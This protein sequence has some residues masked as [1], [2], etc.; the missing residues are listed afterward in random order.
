M[1]NDYNFNFV[2]FGATGDLT[3]RKLIPALYNLYKNKYINDFLITCIA[4]KDYTNESF[5]DELKTFYKKDLM[6]KLD[7]KL[8]VKFAKKIHYYR[9][10]F[11]NLKNI[12]GLDLFFSNIEKINKIKANRLYYLATL[13]QNYELIINSIK[14]CSLDNEKDGWKRLIIEKPFG[15]SLESAKRLNKILREA[16]REDQIFRIDHYLSKETLNNLLI[17]RFANTIFEPIWS[18]RYIDHVQ[19]TVAEDLGVLDRGAYYDKSGAIRDMLQNHLLQ[20]LTM[21]AMECPGEFVASR[22]RERKVDVLKSVKVDNFILGQYQGYRNEQN[23]EKNSNTETYVSLKLFINNSNWK[24]VPFYIRTGKKMKKKSAFIYIKFKEIRCIT[25]KRLNMFPNELIIQIQPEQNIYFYINSKVPGLDLGIAKV[26][27][28]FCY[29][30]VYGS[31]TLE[32]YEKMISEAVKGDLSLFTSWEESKVAWKIVDNIL[33][34]NKKV[35]FYKQV[36]YGPDESDELLKK[37]GR[38]WHYY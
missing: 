21:V 22:I 7:E 25:D 6:K 12:C 19:I 26:K 33:S 3:K 32:A 1:K 24:G 11:D 35:S 37:D 15:S 10:D 23:V 38:E 20:I 34:K 31:N 4:R 16:F 30:C 29:E 28:D 2:I 27:L 14:K 13:P 17:F 8:W 36:T 9:T 18:N 5:A